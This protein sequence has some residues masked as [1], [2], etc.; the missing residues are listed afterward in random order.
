MRSSRLI[1]LGML[2]VVLACA[3]IAGRDMVPEMAGLRRAD[4]AVQAARLAQETLEASA[5][6][7]RER[8]VTL[9]WV[10]NLTITDQAR[11]AMFATS[12]AETDASLEAVDKT[13]SETDPAPFAT[14]QQ[15]IGAVRNA[16]AAQRTLVDQM[17]ATS[18]ATLDFTR[19]RMKMV[20]VSHLFE[21]GLDSLEN[22][23]SRAEPRLTGLMLSARLSVTLRNAVGRFAVQIAPA[24]MAKRPVTPSEIEEM[25]QALGAIDVLQAE[26]RQS[27]E[28]LD[29]RTM[30]AEDKQRLDVDVLGAGLD[31]ARQSA[32][33]GRTG[34]HYAMTS[35]EFANRFAQ[36]MQPLMA[37]RTSLSG[38]LVEDAKTLRAARR[39]SLTLNALAVLALLVTMIGVYL[40][41][42]RRIAAPLMAIHAALLDLQAGR[43]TIRLPQTAPGGRMA[44]VSCA[45]FALRDTLVAEECR[46]GELE[47]ERLERERRTATLFEL[48]EAFRQEMSVMGQA[49]SSAAAELEQTAHAM[50][51]T[52]TSTNKEIATVTSATEQATG[53]VLSIADAVSRLTTCIQAISRQV[54]LSSEQ[55]AAAVADARRAGTTVQTLSNAAQ[56]IGTVVGMIGTISKQTHMLAL[57]A[58]IE[59]AR[60]GSAGRGFAVVA[61]EVKKLAQQTSAATDVIEAQVAQIQSATLDAVGAIQGITASIEEVGGIATT[62]VTAI[63]QQGLST[64]EISGHAQRTALIAEAVT[65]TMVSV[66]GASDRTEAA[67]SKV[68]HA[69]SALSQQ[70]DALS[71]ESLVVSSQLERMREQDS[72]ERDEAWS[73]WLHGTDDASDTP[74]SGDVNKIAA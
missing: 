41:F 32:L 13:L 68:L 27:L 11:S 9:R 5:A 48:G 69:A 20:G 53:A 62:I 25:D 45:L 31:L 64:R 36:A 19:L 28:K 34:G 44:E 55:T 21:P 33:A 8:V 29:R 49:M 43:R 22:I 58:T 38:R 57:N 15:A 72:K 73:T 47:A 14:L 23:L 10:N 7:L 74:R 17:S 50:S 59:A 65:Q 6:I 26:F 12:R 24:I 67:A 3:V 18:A 2:V 4:R 30:S 56:K 71:K 54:A 60:A 46:R 70:S 35:D 37:V 51:G 16:L 63:E 40:Q 66:R 1:T 39:Q 52:A 61:S 42:R